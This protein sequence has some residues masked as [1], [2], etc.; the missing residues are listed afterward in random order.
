MIVG[1]DQS[2]T[3][4]AVV[5][6][7]GTK[8]VTNIIR[9]TPD[10][11]VYARAEAITSAVIKLANEYKPSKINIEGLAFASRGN[12]T[13][14][15]AGLQMMIVCGL[16]KAGYDPKII[17]PNTLKKHATGKGNAD[18]EAMHTALPDDIK[19]QFKDIKKTKGLSDVVDAYWLSTMST[20]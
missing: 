8:F 17:A 14:D 20:Q 13:R 4:T 2:Y 7:D 19:Q 3:S 18:K 5:A 1:I 9:T 11:D 12:A 6:N 16:R 15:L 10:K